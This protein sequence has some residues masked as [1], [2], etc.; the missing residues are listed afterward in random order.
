[1][2]RR[3]LR[4]A[5]AIS[6]TAVLVFGIPL[7][8]A[9]TRLIHADVRQ[10]LEHDADNIASTVEDN[11]EHG[12]VLTTSILAN[13]APAGQHVIVV[14]RDGKV[15]T[16]GKRISGPKLEVRSDAA[17][18]AVVYVQTSAA[19]VNARVRRLWLLVAALAA[20]GVAAGATLALL[21]ARRLSA[22]LDALA[23]SSR[24]LGSGD[25]SA[26][27]AKD[28]IPEMDAVADA[29]NASAA[30]I[31]ELVATERRFATNVSHQ[32]RTP[33]TAIR[34]R[35]EELVSSENLEQAREEAR[36]AVQQVDRL[37]KTINELLEFTRTGH[38]GGK[39]EIDLAALVRSHIDNWRDG[40]RA[41]EIAVTFQSEDP[42]ARV[43]ARPGVVGQALDVLLDNSIKH[44]GGVVEV[45]I[46]KRNGQVV[47]QVADQG[48]GVP[49]GMEDHIFEW[50]MTTG[51]GL[52]VGLPLA[53]TLV[54]SDGGRLTL[55]RTRPAQFEIALPAADHTQ[56]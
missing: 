7:A 56:A 45:S 55:T 22:P 49:E 51:D 50:S 9:G 37:T 23:K 18:D 20:G 5:I 21:Q 32:L 34:I 53:R 47:I 4:S 40:Y 39:T 48:T 15:L 27:A 44:G 1:V 29:L 19:G 24:R 43:R 28:G 41:S 2:K 16:A 10:G 11:F 35:L 33:I 52:G 3:M 17:K 6:L 14:G 54:E 26:R 36:A 12:R 13:V 42:D 46:E 25:F 31:A 30:Q 8:I 38:F